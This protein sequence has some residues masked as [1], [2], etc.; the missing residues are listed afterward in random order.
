MSQQ[1]FLSDQFEAHRAHLGRVAYRMLGSYVEAEDAVQEA[2][3]RLSR[4]DVAQ[5]SNLG[6]WLT[7]VVSRVCL[8]LLRARRSRREDLLGPEAPDLAMDEDDSLFPGREMLLADSVGLA[9]LVV[10]EALPPAERAAFVLHDL[11][12]LPFDEIAPIVGRTSDATRQLASRARRRVRGATT[13]ARTDLERQRKVVEAFLAASRGGDLGAL[14]DVLAPDVVCRADPA[15]VQ[16]G[17]AAELRGVD[18]VAPAFVGRARSARPVLV[19]GGLGAA[20]MVDG[21]LLLVLL[22]S[23]AGD[24]VAAIEAVADKARI[25]RM[26]LVMLD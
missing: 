23:V 12:D 16:L 17:G 19:D 10:L 1:N 13:P 9:L 6:G 26:D 25:A 3:I 5:V 4:S 18:A 7:T 20:V 2:W 14:L 22:V 24:R 11:F 8:D 21:K 15:A